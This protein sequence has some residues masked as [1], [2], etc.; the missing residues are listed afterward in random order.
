MGLTKR[1]LLTYLARVGEADANDVAREFGVRYS[2]AAMGLLRLARQS[3]A[4]RRAER[5]VYRY[6]LSERGLS[7]LAYFTG[8][9]RSMDSGQGGTQTGTGE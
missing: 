7:R 8:A 3:L 5:G 1:S 2:V 4:M 6:R 9:G